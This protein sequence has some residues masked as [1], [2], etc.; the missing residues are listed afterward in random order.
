M[1][2]KQGL[3]D[4]KTLKGKGVKTITIAY[5]GG[6]SSSGIKTLQNM[7]KKVGLKMLL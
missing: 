1:N 4:I 3:K 6:I 7:L 2:H 5:G